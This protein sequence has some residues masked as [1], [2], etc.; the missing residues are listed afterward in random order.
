VRRWREGWRN[1][2]DAFLALF[3]AEGPP[4]PA[5]LAVAADGLAAALRTP[6]PRDVLAEHIFFPSAFRKHALHAHRLFRLVQREIPAGKHP[7]EGVA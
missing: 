6:L 1:R 3:V 4:D 5:A 2:L 7:L